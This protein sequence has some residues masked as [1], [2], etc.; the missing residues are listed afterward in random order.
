MY[1]RKYR[2]TALILSVVMMIS[3]LTGCSSTETPQ[4]QPEE[5]MPVATQTPMITPTPEPTP[6]PL[7][8]ELFTKTVRDFEGYPVETFD[9]SG[10]TN[11]IVYQ[12]ELKQLSREE[13]TNILVQ[14]DFD[15]QVFVFEN[16]DESLVNCQVGDT[17]LMP[18]SSSE[19]SSFAFSVESFE[20]NDNTITINGSQPAMEDIFAYAEVNTDISLEQYASSADDSDDENSDSAGLPDVY[21]SN[22]YPL[23]IFLD[24]TINADFGV[25]DVTTT[26]WISFDNF[27]LEMYFFPEEHYIYTNCWVDSNYGFSIDV[28]A[29]GDSGTTVHDPLSVNLCPKPIPVPVG[30][31]LGVQ[32]DPIAEIDFSGKLS[33]DLTW[34]AAGRAGYKFSCGLLTENE[35]PHLTWQKLKEPETNI[36]LKK[37]EGKCSFALDFKLFIGIKNVGEIYA[38]PVV[39]VEFIGKPDKT[40]GKKEE[41]M[42][43]D[44]VHDCDLC[45]DGDAEAFFEMRLGA[46]FCLK[47]S[48]NGAK[49]VYP[50]VVGTLLRFVWNKGDFYISRIDDEFDWGFEECPHIRYRCVVEVADKDRFKL[51]DV[52]VVATYEDGRTEKKTTT[53]DGYALVYLPYGAHVV[54]ASKGSDS[55]SKVVTMGKEPVSVLILLNE[56]KKVYFLYD[57]DKMGIGQPGV[58][59]T[60]DDFPELKQLILD[61][62][63]G[64]TFHNMS[65]GSKPEQ[66]KVGDVIIKYRNE[67][68]HWG[69]YE[70]GVLTEGVM[71]YTQNGFDVFLFD[72]YEAEY[73]IFNSWWYATWENPSRNKNDYTVYYDVDDFLPCGVAVE[74]NLVTRIGVVEEHSH[75]NINSRKIAPLKVG[76][77]ENSL[78]EKVTEHFKNATIEH[79]SN[80]LPVVDA[81]LDREAPI[82]NAIENYVTR[83]AG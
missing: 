68:S 27:H 82:C 72:K 7:R 70:N 2:F 21:I 35:I 75:P 11:F 19:F 65:D 23:G 10:E 49:G 80:I 24:K 13:S 14:A 33:G 50:R 71:N 15:N 29:E 30:A 31:A 77:F 46:H 1:S 64:V 18:N 58:S 69:N 62:Y 73:C 52:D 6:E 44:S 20:I 83:T 56:S 55:N 74:D 25:V 3:L 26:Q 41:A 63:P 5:P 47:K 45:I 61:K 42:N 12:K 57:I 53:K 38:S 9:D 22:D 54:S 78:S 37:L 8:E 76:S 60:I 59:G 66:Y 81:I 16:P 43:I 28:G 48:V 40:A 51:A 39:G 67:A 4:S 32:F 36:N 34:S 17:F 79:I